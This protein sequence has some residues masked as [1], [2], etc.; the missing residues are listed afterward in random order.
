[1]HA[2]ND[3]ILSLIQERE[4]LFPCY[5]W[6]PFQEG[7][8]RLTRLYIFD[9][10]LHWDTSSCE[11]WGSAEDFR[12]G[13]DNLPGH[14]KHGMQKRIRLQPSKVITGSFECVPISYCLPPAFLMYIL[15]LKFL[16]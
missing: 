16:N 10:S 11:Y 14:R 9:E 13:G 15:P 1:M 7:F 5:G 3:K 12:G 6:K 4:H 2:R 8:N